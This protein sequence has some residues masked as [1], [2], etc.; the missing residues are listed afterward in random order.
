MLVS[1]VIPLTENSELR[2]WH[3]MQAQLGQHFGE[4]Y[5]GGVVEASINGGPWQLLYPESG[6]DF[7]ISESLTPGPFP[8][9]TPVFSGYYPWREEIIQ[10][11]GHTGTIQF[12]FRF[13]S[14]EQIG[15]EGWYI[16]DVC[17]I[18]RQP[19]SGAEEEP[20]PLAPALSVG[21][22]NPFR[23]S[24][25]ILVNVARPGP[26]DLSILDLEGRVLRH[27][28]RGIRAAGRHRIVWNGLD[29]DGR[30]VPS[31]LYFYRLRSENDAFEDVRRVIRLR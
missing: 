30:A 11:A 18:G 21:G 24:T 7:I 10:I 22:P 27:L 29:E 1:P 4:A 23:E 28:E 17:F 2:F 26:V 5:D 15:L 16:D 31:G 9:H 20:I 8:A 25:V 14:D 12:R 3:F 13:G 19:S 6:Y